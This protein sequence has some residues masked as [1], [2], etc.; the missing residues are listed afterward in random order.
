[1]PS[2]ITLYP[3]FTAADGDCL[4]HCIDAYR[5]LTTKEIRVRMAI[6]SALFK[7]HYPRNNFLRYGRTDISTSSLAAQYSMYFKHLMP[8]SQLS[9][10]DIYCKD[11]QQCIS[12][13]IDL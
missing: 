4:A 2:N 12:I 3:A 9:D 13:G 8:N 7:D 6:E 11:V 10:D 1:M 5:N